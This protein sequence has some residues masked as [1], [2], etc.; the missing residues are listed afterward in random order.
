MTVNVVGAVTV[1]ASLTAVIVCERTTVALEYWVV[2]PTVVMFKPVWK[3]TAPEL[4]SIRWAV[5]VG[6]EPAKFAAGKNRKE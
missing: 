6:A 3:L 5:I 1:G 4:S 2:A